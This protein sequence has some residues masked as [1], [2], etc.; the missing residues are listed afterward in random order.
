M[1]KMADYQKQIRIGSGNVDEGSHLTVTSAMEEFQDMVTEQCNILG[2]SGFAMKEKYNSFWV[3]TKSKVIIDRMP[4]WGER[5]NMCAFPSKPTSRFCNWNC[6]ALD[7]D[8]E[9]LW[10]AKSEMCILDFENQNITRMKSVWDTSDCEFKDG[11]DV[12]F[13]R[14][15]QPEDGEKVYTHRI[16]YSDIDMSH[17]TNNVKYNT[18]ALNAFTCSEISSMKIR[19]YE[20]DFVSQSHEGDDI[21]VF[22][23]QNE[24]EWLVWGVAAQDSRLVFDVRMIVEYI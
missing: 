10:H 24:N 17:H 19:E 9:P 23:K 14:F 20:I 1:I 12:S 7:S 18:I 5:V 16:Q 21:E 4:F 3:V 15:K 6:I 8:E 2:I 11:L 13:E 22:R